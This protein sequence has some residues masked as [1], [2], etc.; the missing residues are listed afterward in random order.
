MIRRTSGRGRNSLVLVTTVGMATLLAACGGGGGGAPPAAGGGPGDGGYVLGVSNMTV[1][2]GWREEMICAVKAEALAS[3]A[4]SKVIVSS[5]NGAVPE[6]KAN[7]RNLISQGVDA[8]IVNPTSPDQ[9]N[10]VLDQAAERGITVVSVDQAVTTEKAYV[11]SNNQET[12]GRLGAEWLVGQLGAAGGTVVELR[13]G[14]GAPAD[15]ARHTGFMSVM[16][17]HPEITIVE[18]YTN[19]SFSEANQIMLDLLNSSQ[20]IDGVWTS[21]QDYTVVNAFTTLGEPFVPIVGSDTNEFIKQMI[22]LKD[23]GLTAAAV[24][25]PATIGG[26]GAS[27]ALS[28]LAG[29]NV[30]R[31]TELEPEV[32]TTEMSD[33]ELTSHYLPDQPPTYSTQ[34][35]IEPHTDYAV[36]HLLACKGPG[37]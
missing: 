30:E 9:L 22:D 16:E 1:G 27:I 15:I 25:N 21:G 17:Q 6:Q 13:G 29:E 20:Q 24:T 19:W 2:N 8:V 23:E 11:A 26:V 32:Y 33:E 18:R 4:V 28:V 37:E 14:Q 12:Y 3:G 31:V 7:I 10:D 35:Q 5:E 34:L 36:E